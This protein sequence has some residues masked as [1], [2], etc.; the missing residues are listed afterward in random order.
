MWLAFNFVARWVKPDPRFPSA[1]SLKVNR[2][3]AAMLLC[4]LVLQVNTILLADESE[5]DNRLEVPEGFH[6][7]RATSPALVERPMFASLDAE[8]GLYVLDSGGVNGNDR[9]AKPPDVVRYLTDTDGDGIYDKSVLFAD[10]I[11]FGTGLVCY[12]NAVYVTSP[13]S[14]WKLE[15]QT[16]DGQ[17]DKQ[18]ELITGFAFNQSCTDDVHGACLGPDGRIYFLPGRFHHKIQV[19]GGP[20]IVEGVGPWLMRCRPDGREA[21]VVSGAVGNPVEVA[22]LPSGDAFVQGTF[23]AKPSAEGGLRDAVIHAVAGGEYSVRDRDYSDRVRTGDYLPALVPLTATAPSGLMAYQSDRWGREYEGNLFTS[24]FNTG[25]I[26]RHRL[27]PRGGT[28]TCETEDFVTATQSDVHFTDVLEDADGSLLVVDTGGWY[29]ACCPA[30]QSSKPEVKGAIYRV[31]RDRSPAISDPYGNKLKWMQAKVSDLTERLDDSRFA[32]RERAIV[33]LSQRGAESVAGLANVLQASESS[34]QQRRCA[35]WALCRIDEPTAREATKIALND[36]DDDV[37]QVAA[38]SAGLHRDETAL[39]PLIALLSDDSLVIR[40]EAANAL[41]RIGRREAVPRLLAT[42]GDLSEGAAVSTDRFVEHALIYAIISINDATATRLGLEAEGHAERRAALIA[43][44]Q[45]PTTKLGADDIAPILATGDAALVQTAIDI[46]ARHPEWTD[47]SISLVDRWLKSDQIEENLAITLTGFVRALHRDDAMK[48]V[49]NRH[50]RDQAK[51]TSSS[52]QALL[53]ALAKS[54]EQEVPIEWKRGITLALHATDP[55]VRLAAI[56]ATEALSLKE[57]SNELHR[58]ANDRASD[59]STRL[60]ALQSLAVLQQEL[61]EQEFDY[62]LSQLGQDAPTNDRLIALD[63]LAKAHQSRKRLG[64]VLPFVETASPIEMPFYLSVFSHGTDSELG[65]GLIR[66]L[67]SSTTNPSPEMVA[68]TLKPYDA[69]VQQAALPLLERLRQSMRDQVARLN[70]LET[71]LDQYP[72]NPERGK[73]V[74]FGKAQCH[75]CHIVAGR[76]GKVGPDLSAIGEIRSRRD[77]LEAVAFPS[78]TFAR[79]F[80]PMTVVLEDG[81]VL[82]GLAGRETAEEIVL[83]VFKNNQP[84]E[85]PLSRKTIEDVQ[86]GRVSMMPNGLD[87]QLEPQELSDLIQYLQQLRR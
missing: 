36:P 48:Q 53:R 78:A 30:S 55:A 19:P 25:R 31:T 18:T 49:I 71:L 7:T 2:T 74:Y 75:L 56:E 66:S 59:K 51:L 77:L 80:E 23:W 65:L 72:G 42:I 14:L 29:H 58:I 81:R 85:V 9:G 47:M 45:M 70:Q 28:F 32:V 68:Q 57:L 61:S 64:R 13:P 84:V 5:G 37:R 12:D 67:E 38:Q 69:S 33:A 3:S 20:M 63:I 79:G 54:G 62:L 39:V 76:G 1:E 34:S 35:V 21:E 83:M 40:R 50:L 86:I 22:F 26:L 8:G 60:H 4:L 46:L 44:D 43:L 41:G 82:T 10:K 6:V 17:A 87:H 15:D 11:V 27:T 16:G 24:H 73:E 52:L